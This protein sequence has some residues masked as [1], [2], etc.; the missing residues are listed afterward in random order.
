M[1]VN[2]V[3]VA[4]TLTLLRMAMNLLKMQAL[5]NELHRTPCLPDSERYK[6]FEANFPYKPT[7]DQELCFRVE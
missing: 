4:D 1:I 3:T 5:R 2:T 7:Q 6:E